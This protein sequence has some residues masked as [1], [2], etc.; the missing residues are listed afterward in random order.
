MS[1]FYF[2]L[3]F[4]FFPCQ[5]L[6]KLRGL[7]PTWRAE[8]FPFYAFSSF[9]EWGQR[10][11]QGGLCR[12]S[13]AGWAAHHRGEDDEPQHRSHREGRYRGGSRKLP[14]APR[15]PALLLLL[16]LSRSSSAGAAL[17]DLAKH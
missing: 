12:A 17:L 7:V 9:F 5:S 14:G 3:G 10:L 15:T 1:D 13:R 2:I 16:L 6:R 8:S 4:F 11:V